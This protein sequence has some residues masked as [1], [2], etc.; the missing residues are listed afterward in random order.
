MLKIG[1]IQYAN[2]TPIFHVLVEQ[3]EARGGQHELVYGVPSAL[4][5]LLSS[6]CL[7]VCPSSSIEYALH[8]DRYAILPNVSISSI[9]EVASVLLLSRGPI[10]ELDGKVIL[11]SSESATSVNLL[12][13]LIAQRYGLNCEYR[14]CSLKMLE[15]ESDAGALL[16]IGDAALNAS[17]DP[18]GLHV[19]DLGRLWHEWT[20]LPF[21]FALWI[22]R[23][24]VASTMELQLLCKDLVDAKQ[25]AARRYAELARC[26]TDVTALDYDRLLAYW[27]DN[28][29]FDLDEQ[30][31]QGLRLYYEKAFHSGLIPQVPPLRFVAV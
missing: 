4:N 27:R 13:I 22:C 12:K 6:G 5:H 21:V 30:H 31:Q 28:I 2:C 26:Y 24:E 20:G 18:N 19:Y 15:A 1:R 9:S 25:S 10:E 8:A 17:C 11:L 7:D 3:W 16:L 29:S 23:I 14:V